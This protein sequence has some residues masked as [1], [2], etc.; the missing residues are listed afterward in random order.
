M[1]KIEMLSAGQGDALWIEYG[2]EESP[3]RIIIDGGNA[4]SYPDGLHARILQLPKED[5]FFELLVVT[6]VDLDHIGGALKLV[7]DKKLGATFGDIWFNGFEQLTSKD[8]LGPKEGDKLTEEI[9]NQGL[10]WNQAFDGHAVVVPVDGDLP[11]ITLPGDLKL[12]LFSPYRAA[13]DRLRDVW[14]IVTGRAGIGESGEVTGEPEPE[15]EEE[16]PA[17]VLGDDVNVSEWATTKTPVDKAE[18]NGSSIAFLLEFEG[19]RVLLAGDAHP[20]QL[21]SSI[22]RMVG[23]DTPLDLTAFKLPHHGSKANVTKDLLQ[24]VNCKHYLISSGG[25]T[26]PDKFAISRI[27]QFGGASPHLHFNCKNEPALLWDSDELRDKHGYETTYPNDGD[28]GLPV[29]ITTL[30]IDQ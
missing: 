5:R 16:G 25:D 2:P 24:A 4:G 11:T 7:K 3:H 13:L 6:H 10:V 21:T 8:E 26:R 19:H 17:D 28:N 23:K 29:D 15:E 30:P 9:T 18:A 27:L 22:E 1:L 14:I 12:T 20:D